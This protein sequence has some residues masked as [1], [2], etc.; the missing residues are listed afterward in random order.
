MFD[1]G[2]QVPSDRSVPGTL[3]HRTYKQ[4]KEA[5]PLIKERNLYFQAM[6]TTPYRHLCMLTTSTIFSVSWSM[7]GFVMDSIMTRLPSFLRNWLASR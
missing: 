4:K 6:H 7:I 1:E 5:S 3:T 2:Y